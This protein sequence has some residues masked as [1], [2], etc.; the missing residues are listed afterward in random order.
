MALLSRHGVPADKVYVF[1]ANAEE[2]ALYKDA[3][4]DSWPN[5]VEGEPTLWRRRNF[6]ANYFEE[7][8]DIISLD[9]DV[10]NFIELSKKKKET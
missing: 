7:G 3:L 8:R 5:V 2:L 10:E 1:V 9:D 6:I 4:G